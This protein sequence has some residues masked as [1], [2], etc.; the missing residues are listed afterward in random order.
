MHHRIYEDDDG[1][2]VQEFDS[3]AIRYF[4]DG[5]ERLLEAEPGDMMTTPSIET[6]EDGLPESVQEFILLR[7]E[8]EDE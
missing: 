5:L 3:E 1:N 2:L 8:D 7:V 6:D 4:I